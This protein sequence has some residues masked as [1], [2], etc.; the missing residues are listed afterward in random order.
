MAGHFADVGKSGWDPNVERPEF[1]EMMAAVRAGHVDAVVIK[2][3]SAPTANGVR[4]WRSPGS[5]LVSMK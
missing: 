4:K 1:E 2:A 3:S 5:R